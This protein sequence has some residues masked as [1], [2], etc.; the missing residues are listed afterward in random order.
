MLK[1]IC[2]SCIYHWTY[3]TSGRLG[4]NEGVHS[5]SLLPLFVCLFVLFIVFLFFFFFRSCLRFGLDLA[6]GGILVVRK[7]G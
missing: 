6:F 5:L 1:G 7:G 2:V 4:A 3:Y